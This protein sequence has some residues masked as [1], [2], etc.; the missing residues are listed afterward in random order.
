MNKKNPKLT[1]LRPPS[2][3]ENA[4]SKLLAA[5]KDIVLD[6][7]RHGI[8]HK[9]ADAYLSQ[10]GLLTL[11]FAR[12]SRDRTLNFDETLH[13]AKAIKMSRLVSPKM[14]VWRLPCRL[15]RL[16]YRSWIFHFTLGGLVYLHSIHQGPKRRHHHI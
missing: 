11:K 13:F 2:R 6:A 5:D 4:S 3:H 12:L 16:C 9:D 1:S 15:E 8:L 14:E 7:T 10:S